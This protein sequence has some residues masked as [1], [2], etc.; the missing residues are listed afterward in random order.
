MNFRFH[1]HAQAEYEES[2]LY[3][4]SQQVRLGERFIG[5]IESAIESVLSAPEMWPE[6]EAPVRRRLARVFPYAI[7]Y[8]PFPDHV[9]IVAVMH[10]H[11]EPGYWRARLG[12]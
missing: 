1:P 7:L 12:G 11:Q 4:E 3:Y 6:L 5:S 9:L 10:C 8:V 2:V